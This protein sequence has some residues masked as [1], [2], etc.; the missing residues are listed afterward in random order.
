MCTCVDFVLHIDPSV[1]RTLSTS[2]R[3]Y[4]TN[5]V[6]LCFAKL[7]Q[8]PTLILLIDHNISYNTCL[9][10]RYIRVSW[11]TVFGFWVFEKIM[12]SRATFLNNY[13]YITVNLL[14][15]ANSCIIDIGSYWYL[16][17]SINVFLYMYNKHELYI[18]FCA[19]IKRC[20]GVRVRLCLGLWQIYPAGSTSSIRS[21]VNFRHA[22]DI[23][24]GG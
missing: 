24:T 23:I 22:L 17:I 7:L 10:K 18:I 13:A 9:P 4:G 6:A 5:T 11:V 21:S 15:H 12:L 8:V 16:F 3:I 14:G 19:I 20:V 1:C 2:Y